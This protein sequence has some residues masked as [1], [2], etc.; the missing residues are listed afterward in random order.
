MK[1]L[2][3]VFALFLMIP[4]FAGAVSDEQWLYAREISQR[5]V[6]EHDNKLPDLVKKAASGVDKEGKALVV[7]SKG[8]TELSKK[9]LDVETASNY[10]IP[11]QVIN[12]QGV[13]VHL[14]KLYRTPVKF[15]PGVDLELYTADYYDELDNIHGVSDLY[16]HIG[17]KYMP[18]FHSEGY[19]HG[20]KVFWLDQTEKESPLFF[21]VGQFG[22]GTRVDKTLYALDKDKIA[23]IPQM[24]FDDPEKIDPKDFIQKKL[25][26]SVWL[27]G[28]TFYQDL[29][30]DNTLEIVNV[31]QAVYPDDLKAK[32][33]KKYWFVNTDYTHSFRKTATVF[34]WNDKKQQFDELGEF[35]F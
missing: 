19:S 26:W 34:Q 30:G 2:L 29:A 24:L 3:A 10:G 5:W 12:S 9:S 20:I 1:H 6:E 7:A 35:Y 22:G 32:L 11:S 16:I 17:L 8:L 18:F 4:G 14:M 25:T 13:T 27:S 33:A 21:E 23:G 15:V 28:E 31:S